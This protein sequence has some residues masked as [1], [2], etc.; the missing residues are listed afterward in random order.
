M[1]M[2]MMMLMPCVRLCIHTSVG[3]PGM[4]S[5]ACLW[6]EWAGTV[7]LAGAVYHVGQHI[8]SLFLGAFGL[9]WVVS[10]LGLRAS[11]QSMASGSFAAARSPVPALIRL[12]C[13]FCV[14][15]SDATA[16][17]GELLLKQRITACCS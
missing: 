1:M 17:R 9:G 13:S 10:R 5:R 2:T 16:A 3:C 11:V 8:S 6:V 12:A 14:R 15:R 4:D 7:Y